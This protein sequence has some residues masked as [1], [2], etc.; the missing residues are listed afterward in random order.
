MT[1]AIKLKINREWLL[2]YGSFVFPGSPR[3]STIARLMRVKFF[4]KTKTN[5][6]NLLRSRWKMIEISKKVRSQSL[7]FTIKPKGYLLQATK[8]WEKLIVLNR[9]RK[10]ATTPKEKVNF[11]SLKRVKFVKMTIFYSL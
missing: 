8:L 9:R 2:Q 6:G 11:L 10:K 5:I 1:S 4:T 3:T 7:N